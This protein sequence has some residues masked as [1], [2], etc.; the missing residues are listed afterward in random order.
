MIWSVRD[1]ATIN[2]PD[3]SSPDS[4][5]RAARRNGRNDLAFSTYLTR[6]QPRMSSPRCSLPNDADH[7]TKPPP[8][9]LNLTHY[10][11]KEWEKHSLTNSYFSN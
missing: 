10:Y 7:F 2:Y 3:P 4:R 11:L 5:A 6:S 9:V 1:M 8:S